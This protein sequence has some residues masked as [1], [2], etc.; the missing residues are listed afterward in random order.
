MG[1]SLTHAGKTLHKLRT[2]WDLP[3]K[4]FHS[5]ICADETFTTR[6][7]FLKDR[8]TCPGTQEKF[9]LPANLIP[10]RSTILSSN[11]FCS[12]RLPLLRTRSPNST[13]R[14]RLTRRLTNL[15]VIPCQS[16]L[17]RVQYRIDFPLIHFGTHALQPGTLLLG[18]M[19]AVVA[20]LGG[21]L[22]L[23]WVSEAG[24]HV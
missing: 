6:P 11:P 16:P 4:T 3:T 10:F 1:S 15:R 19:C 21:C 14:P 2:L 24:V 8:K 12:L 7:F 9:P 20:E 23:A 17:L 22:T 13:P 5:F 18:G